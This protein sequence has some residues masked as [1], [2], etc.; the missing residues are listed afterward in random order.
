VAKNWIMG[1]REMVRQGK[2]LLHRCED[3]SSDPRS[4]HKAGVIGSASVMLAV[5]RADG[6]QT[7]ES[8]EAHRPVGVLSGR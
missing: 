4:P 6:K 1:A 2:C 7:E 8:L 3:L 5:L